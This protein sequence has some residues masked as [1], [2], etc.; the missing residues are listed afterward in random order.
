MSDDTERADA[1]FG[2]RAVWILAGLGGLSLLVGLFAGQLGGGPEDPRTAHP[3]ARDRGALGHRAFLELLRAEDR[4][5]RTSAWRTELELGDD[6]VLLLLEPDLRVEGARDRLRRLVDRSERTLLVL[7]KWR[8]HREERGSDRVERVWTMARDEVEEVLDAAGIGGDVVRRDDLGAWTAPEPAPTLAHPQLVDASGDTPVAV[9]ADGSLFFELRPDGRRILVLADPDVLANHGLGDGDNAAF[10]TGLVDRLAD[11]GD[12]LVVDESMHGREVRPGLWAALLRWPLVL[13]PIQALLVAGAL[14]WAGVGRFGSPLP[15]APALRA[16]R[17]TLVENTVSLLVSGGHA[18]DLVRRYESATR[19]R[20]AE[21][22][23][24]PARLSTPERDARL[25]A[26]ADAR[27]VETPAVGGLGEALLAREGEGR[28]ARP[29]R[30]RALLDRART[31]HHW[32]EEML[33]GAGRR[34]RAR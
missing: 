28:A 24:L 12:E 2:R 32:R 15:S 14:L 6:T 3:H 1:P 31:V 11:R 20:V 19:A 21:A 22:F 16:G 27:D 13:L 10:V 29:V 5:V 26:L 4:S 9:P 8:S 17:D 25:E 34:P 30:L 33:H 7:P 18:A 23:H